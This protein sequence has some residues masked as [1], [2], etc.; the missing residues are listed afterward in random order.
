MELQDWF[1]IELPKFTRVW[2]EYF[3]EDSNYA[4]YQNH[5]KREPKSGATIIG[6]GGWRKDRWP[7]P[8][9]RKGKRGG[10]RIIYLQVPEVRAI[11][12]ASI[13][14]KDKKDDLTSEEKDVL[15]ILAQN[16]KKDLLIRFKQE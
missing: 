14:D 9:R 15:K 5:L 1:F 3:L 6:A 12:L 11:I 4:L 7:D 10:L 8:R 13:Y 16:I 2:Q